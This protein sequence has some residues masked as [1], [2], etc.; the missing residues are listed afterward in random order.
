VSDLDPVPAGTLD[1]AVPAPGALVQLLA[2][3]GYE[4]ALVYV[5][6]NVGDGDSQVLLLPPDRRTGARRVVVVDVAT[7]KKVP[8][9]LRELHAVGLL[10]DPAGSPRQV[11]LLVATHP[12]LDHIGG[13]VDLLDLDPQDAGFVEEIWDPGF[14]FP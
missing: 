13:M 11:R 6:L 8:A 1:P 10:A 3:P 12:H 4:T 14:F 9:L 5:L 7:T 2:S